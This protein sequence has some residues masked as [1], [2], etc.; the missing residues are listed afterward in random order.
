MLHVAVALERNR[1]DPVVHLVVTLRRKFLGSCGYVR[2][3]WRL[4]KMDA[5]RVSTFSSFCATH[6]ATT[7]V[8][9]GSSSMFLHSTR[10]EACFGN[11]LPH[12][13]ASVKLEVRMVGSHCA[14][15]APTS[16]TRLSGAGRNHFRVL[17]H[18]AQYEKANE[19]IIARTIFCY[20]LVSTPWSSLLWLLRLCCVFFWC[21]VYAY[22]SRSSLGMAAST[23]GRHLRFPWYV[24]TSHTQQAHCT[25]LRPIDTFVQTCRRELGTSGVAHV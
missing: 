11:V 20:R 12:G 6:L 17:A 19:A 9:Y 8:G 14:R 15:Q 7:C 23:L 2:E 16:A 25:S 21:F 5:G 10:S 1:A 4:I 13:P 22:S 3:P 24:D 18:L